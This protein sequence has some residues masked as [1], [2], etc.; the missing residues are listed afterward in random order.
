VVWIVICAC[1][2]EIERQKSTLLH[3]LCAYMGSERAC[4]S[5]A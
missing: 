1:V 3:F 4:W 5:T 2:L